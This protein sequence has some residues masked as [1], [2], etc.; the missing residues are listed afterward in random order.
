MSTPESSLET[1]IAA[2]I[3]ATLEADDIEGGKTIV[4]T[5]WSRD[6]PTVP[7]KW[8]RD[9]EVRA[10]EPLLDNSGFKLPAKPRVTKKLRTAAVDAG[11]IIGDRDSL[12]SGGTIQVSVYPFSVLGNERRERKQPQLFSSEETNADCKAPMR[13]KRRTSRQEKE[14][15]QQLEL[16]RSKEDTAAAN[17][18][19][20][21]LS[22]RYSKLQN[23]NSSLQDLLDTEVE[24]HKDT[25]Q[26]L[27][28]SRQSGS[29]KALRKMQKRS[30]DNELWRQASADAIKDL[31]V[32]LIQAQRQSA[33][34]E[35]EMNKEMDK[36]KREVSKAEETQKAA[37][38]AREEAE[39]GLEAA[40][41]AKEAAEAVCIAAKEA[42]ERKREEHRKVKQNANRRKKRC[43]ALRQTVRERQLKAVEALVEGVVERTSAIEGSQ[44]KEEALCVLRTALMM[45]RKFRDNRK[46]AMLLFDQ[47]YNLA[48]DLVKGRRQ[49]H[50]ESKAVMLA[51]SMRMGGAYDGMAQLFQWT[52]SRHLRRLFTRGSSKAGVMRES[53]RE[54]V[55]KDWKA[56][57]SIDDFM[58]VILGFDS[59][60]IRKGL[61]Y[62]PS[63]G[64]F[65]GYD[66]E[67]SAAGVGQNV[68]DAFQRKLL[69]DQP[70]VTADKRPL[71]NHYIVFYI[72]KWKDGAKTPVYKAAVATLTGPRLV[73]IYM[74]IESVL[75]SL[76]LKTVSLVGDGAREN[77]AFYRLLSQACGDV[78]ASEYIDAQDVSNAPNVK[79]E[80]ATTSIGFRHPYLGSC[81]W[82]FN[83]SPHLIKCLRNALDNRAMSWVDE[84]GRKHRVDLR[85]L[86]KIFLD[87]QK[88]HGFQCERGMQLCFFELNCWSKMRV[89][90]AS[91]VQSQKMLNLVSAWEREVG[92]VSVAGLKGWIQAV[93]TSWGI[94]NSQF[95]V[96][97]SELKQHKAWTEVA[98]VQPLIDNLEF[99]ARWK[100]LVRDEKEFLH[101]QTYDN[102][103][104]NHLGF[105]SLVKYHVTTESQLSALFLRWCQSDMCEHHFGDVR[106]G[107]KNPTAMQAYARGHKA[108]AMS[109]TIISSKR[110]CEPE[111]GGGALTDQELRDMEKI[112]ND[113]VG[114]INR[115]A[116]ER[117]PGQS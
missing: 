45:A 85:L 105:F 56:P 104:R 15:Q 40:L 36:S 96:P 112:M 9:R 23:E 99:F 12:S 86:K 73:H 63:C 54:F 13:K 97:G 51:L 71:A 8:S 18:Q 58:M 75:V 28:E 102:L 107:G 42:L 57:K 22:R 34:M 79:E 4:W 62:L 100:G 81:V 89:G 82:A 69:N 35:K 5:F 65:V 29:A 109:G 33:A 10:I 44:E 70:E 38:T 106:S 72:R 11:M 91:K 66:E 16:A 1:T 32:Q 60:T 116:E 110:N 113:A 21:S 27:G 41:A 88:S 83:D 2:A 26:K 95:K 31:E 68:V 78:K 53:L 92:T 3:R 117:T 55:G 76:G 61:Y 98:E 37:D 101:Q 90:P 43:Q 24:M 50:E 49:Y 114:R 7:G 25:R 77:G 30:T 17:R 19:I 46:K 47:F 6:I 64:R 20:A 39:K 108:A 80:L 48:M 74:E 14:K 93:N 84:E 67:S 87:M 115:N 52:G 94:M 103:R 59:M 111:A